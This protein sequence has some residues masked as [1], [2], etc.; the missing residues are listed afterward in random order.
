VNIHALADGNIGIMSADWIKVQKPFP[1]D[2]RDQEA[3]LIAMSREHHFGIALRIDDRI[4]IAEDI[5]MDF[6]GKRLDSTA[7]NRLRGLLKS[8]RAGSSDEI[9]ENGQCFLGHGC[10][11]F[12]T[13]IM[14]LL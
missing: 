11:S 5:G 1:I 8:R 13:R 4:G 7:V 6:I 9:F 2:M 10:F 12:I 3:D 14:V